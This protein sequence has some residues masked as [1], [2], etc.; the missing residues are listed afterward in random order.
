MRIGGRIEVIP[1]F[2]RCM[3]A[4]KHGISIPVKDAVTGSGYMIMLRYERLML[5]P[6]SC[7][8]YFEIIH[9]VKK[10]FLFVDAEG[11]YFTLKES[12]PETIKTDKILPAYLTRVRC[13]EMSRPVMCITPYQGV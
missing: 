3:S 1:P 4:C 9:L 6:E 7:K 2:Q 13:I 10:L 12:F 11:R 5:F 8:A